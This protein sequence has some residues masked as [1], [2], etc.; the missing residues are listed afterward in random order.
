MPLFVAAAAVLDMESARQREAGVPNGGEVDEG[1]AYG[2]AS[3]G[4]C[5]IGGEGGLVR[6]RRGRW[7]RPRVYIGC[8]FTGSCGLPAVVR[9]LG[10]LLT[11]STR[12]LNRGEWGQ[13]STGT[14]ESVV[15][16]WIWT[17][18]CRCLEMT[19][20][21]PWSGVDG[22]GAREM[23]NSKKTCRS[24]SRDRRGASLTCPRWRE[25]MERGRDYTCPGPRHVDY[26]LHPT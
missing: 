13:A 18:L 10:A 22:A 6:E 11:G 5:P 17:V 16:A 19:C 26:Y 2:R 3:D 7:C 12:M 14:L 15:G 21:V 8:E 25:E 9:L 23:H 20:I 4:G 1:R 24:N